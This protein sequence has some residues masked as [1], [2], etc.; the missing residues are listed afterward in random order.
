MNENEQLRWKIPSVE[1]QLIESKFRLPA[2]T[3]FNLARL[4]CCPATLRSQM[5]P[6][7]GTSK[8][9][10]FALQGPSRYENSFA[11]KHYLWHHIRICLAASSFERL[12]KSKRKWGGEEVQFTLKALD[13]MWVESTTQISRSS[14]DELKGQISPW[15]KESKKSQP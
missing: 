8:I 9:K 2:A 15:P 3:A 11:A 14:F 7:K 12:P 4:C 13:F 5:H 10:V 1:G 6:A